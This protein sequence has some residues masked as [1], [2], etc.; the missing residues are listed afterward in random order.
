VPQRTL[1]GRVLVIQTVPHHSQDRI[2][3]IAGANIQRFALLTVAA[4]DAVAVVDEPKQASMK[5]PCRGRGSGRAPRQ[6][7]L[8]TRHVAHEVEQSL[9][10]RRPIRAGHEN[11]MTAVVALHLLLRQ[12]EFDSQGEGTEVGVAHVV[13]GGVP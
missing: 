9:K 3:R 11:A 6:T 7:V 2:A 13:L 12:P 5:F 10:T 1:Q 8:P 4:E